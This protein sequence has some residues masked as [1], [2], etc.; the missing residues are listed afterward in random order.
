MSFY[1]K[2]FGAFSMIM[3]IITYLLR[4]I[5]EYWNS[6]GRFTTTSPE[7]SSGAGIQQVLNTHLLNEWMNAVLLYKFFLNVR[8][9]LFKST[10]IYLIAQHVTGDKTHIL[11][12]PEIS[13]LFVLKY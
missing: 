5:K 7:T 3:F 9:N 1:K 11:R 2:A 12:Y 6:V 8:Q 13:C 4:K 10:H